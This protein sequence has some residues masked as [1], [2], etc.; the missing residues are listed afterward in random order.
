MF[1][2]PPLVLSLPMRGVFSICWEMCGNGR[3]I[4]ETAT[5]MGLRRTVVHGRQAIASIIY[6]AGD[7]GS[8]ARGYFGPRPATSAI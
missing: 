3:P 4:V 8:T 6:T 2:P 7:R 1:T 5:T